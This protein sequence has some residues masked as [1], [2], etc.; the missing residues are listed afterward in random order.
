MK[1]FDNT[2]STEPLTPGLLGAI[3]RRLAPVLRENRQR[4]LLALLCLIAAKGG[5]LLIP[6][7]LK[8]LVDGLDAGAEATPLMFLLLLVLAY[9]AARLAN[10]LFG[11]LRDTL[12]GRVTER[13]MRRIGLQVFRH[14]HSL[15]L[16]FHLNRRTGGL[17]RDIERG[18]SGISFLLR[19]FIF[20]IAP[21][22]FEIAMVA[23]ILLFSYGWLYAAIVLASVLL[24]GLYSF[25][26]TAWRTRFVREVNEADSSSNT[27][28]VDSLLNYETVKYFTNEEFEAQRYDESLAT[29]ETARRK[30]RL[31]LFAL[32]GGQALIIAVSQTCM[33]GLAAWQ[34]HGGDMS[35]GDFV[36]VNQFMLQLFMPLGFLGFVYR[37]IKSSLANIERLFELLDK[38]PKVADKP[39]ARE[40]RITEAALEFRGVDFAYED[41]RTILSG[42]TFSIR[43]GEKVAVVGASGGGKSTLVK[44][45]FRFYDPRSGQVLI[46]GQDLRDLTQCSLRRQIAIVPQDCVL[47][48]DSLRENIRYGNPGADEAALQQAIQAAHLE[49]FVERLPDGLDTVVGERGLK[50]SGGERQRVGIAR[51]ALKNAPIL[52]FDEATSSLDS[53]SEQ[54]VLD[55]F[56]AMAVQHT[57]L[58]IAHRLS[59]IVDADRILVLQ[60]GNVVEQGKHHDLLLENGYYSQ[61]WQ[62]QQRRSEQE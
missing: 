35:L 59:T 6:F 15:D 2:G 21:T 53:R 4:V 39:G 19:F 29:W 14:V 49:Q 23:G 17:A 3:Y 47:F 7:L 50:L 58:V 28:A 22:L 25:R 62:A 12:F 5:L 33:L 8:A 13:A 34:V 42:V 61:L 41:T 10:T 52:V 40:L 57:T 30:N 60:D 11:E 1:G 46:D 16:D 38:R 37:E 20:N 31:S 45:L 36:L 24:Y 18:T 51:A 48:N 56:S 32:N 44:L 55:A 26:A 43:G 9:G 27:R 54:A